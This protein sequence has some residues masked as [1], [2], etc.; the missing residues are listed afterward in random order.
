MELIN[1]F[2]P[3]VRLGPGEGGLCLAGIRDRV[4]DITVWRIE[5]GSSDLRVCLRARQAIPVDY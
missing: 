5:G 3:L 1:L 4:V 2:T